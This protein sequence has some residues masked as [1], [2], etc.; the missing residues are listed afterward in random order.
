MSQLLVVV[1]EPMTSPFYNYRQ[2]MNSIKQFPIQNYEKV[3]KCP[4]PGHRAHL[5]FRL[6]PDT[7][8]YIL[9]LDNTAV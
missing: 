8:T 9:R 1:Q 2:T 7:S 3:M 4:T 5:K 6:V